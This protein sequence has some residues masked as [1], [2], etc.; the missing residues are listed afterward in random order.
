VTA[1]TPPLAAAPAGARL[2]PSDLAGLASI[3]LRTRKLRASLSALGIAIG[4]AAIVAVLGL[5]S[6]SQAQ[7]LA[8]IARL[9]TN[10]LTVSS[11]QTLTGQTAELPDTSPGMVGQLPGVT[12]VQYTGTVNNAN[13]YRSPLIPSFDTDALSVTAASLGLPGA[14]GTSIA[15]GRYLNAA[16]AREPVAVLGYETA[17]LMGIDRIWPGMRIWV[18][19]QWFYVAGILNP[20]TLAPQLDTSIL[21]GFPAAEKYLGFDGHP[22]ELYVR[23]VNTQAATT[24]V[25]DLLGYQANPENPSEVSVSQPSSAL[26]AQADAAGAFNTLFLGLGAVALLVGAVGVANIMV[27]SVLERRQ[28][29]GLRRALGA[30]RGQIRI[31]FLSEAIL[32]ALIGGVAGVIAGVVCTAVYAHIKG[33]PTVV[34][35]EAWAGGLAAAI[36]IGALAGLLPA[37]RAARLSPTEALW[38]V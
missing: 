36:L 13:A 21:V 10:L 3:G 20:A 11:G 2:R 28:E 25:D 22:S 27:I 7:L 31:Q 5:A 6:S 26:T 37:I 34:P 38:A 32:L 9:G 18:G 33:W 23:T 19:G 12:A 35:P 17:Q 14:V 16:T 4:V 24:R 1:L 30:T 8:E 29:I 15:E